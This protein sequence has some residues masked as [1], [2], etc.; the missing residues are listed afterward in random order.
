LIIATSHN[1]RGAT[2]NAWCPG[3]VFAA[4]GVAAILI[5]ALAGCSGVTAGHPAA[6]AKPNSKYGTLPSYLPK[7]TFDTDR[8]L[9]GT[10]RRPA[11]TTEGDTVRFGSGA[12][13]VLVTVTGPEVPG[14]GLPFQ[15]GA[16]TCTWTVTIEAGSA[17]VPI[18]PNDFSSS[19]HLG[20]VYAPQLVT[21]Q[22]APPPALAPHTTVTFELRTVM[23]V[24]EGLMRW[25]PDGHHPVASWDF[26]VEND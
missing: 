6:A 14:E 22:S 12:T 26:E 21:G 23:V 2:Q 15:T 10:I 25:S 9:T 20:A 13:A 16:T 17:S 3:G 1:R 11:L 7:Q 5:G 24:G 18:D 4:L 19:D 8:V